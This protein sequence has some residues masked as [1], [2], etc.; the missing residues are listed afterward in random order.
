[1]EGVITTISGPFGALALSIGILW[2][3]ANKVVP[4]LQRYLEAQSTQLA[5][6]VAALNRTIDAH[7]KDRAS[8]ER[9]IA[10]LGS[11]LESVETSVSTLLQ[12]TTNRTA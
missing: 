12:A 6:L 4:V 8:F 1:M 5:G 9:S 2:W 10:R 7:E 3:L 11:R